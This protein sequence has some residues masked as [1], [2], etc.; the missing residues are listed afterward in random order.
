MICPKCHAAELVRD[1]RDMSYGSVRGKATTV[2][3]VTGDFCPACGDVHLDLAELL[4]TSAAK[5]WP[6]SSEPRQA[7]L[8]SI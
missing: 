6:R 5:S 1:T 4:L 3:S 7:L 2:H 8:T